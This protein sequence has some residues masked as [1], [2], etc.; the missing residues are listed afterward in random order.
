MSDNAQV[1][2]KMARGF[3]E[4]ASKGQ[5]FSDEFNRLKPDEQRDAFARMT[6]L[7]QNGAFPAVQLIDYD[8]NGTLDD[9]QSVVGTRLVDVYNKPT[10]STDTPG[11]G[12]RRPR[13][14]G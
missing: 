1:D 13:R 12:T 9:A 4:K 11:N 8:N 3:L 2:D 10:T 6:K 14:G 7:Q 5:S